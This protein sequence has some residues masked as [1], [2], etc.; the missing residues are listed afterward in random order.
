MDYYYYLARNHMSNKQKP[1][2]LGCSG[3]SKTAQVYMDY[4]INQYKDL[5]FN[6]PV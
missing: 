6:Q 4:F 3:G 2:W 5:V 1:G